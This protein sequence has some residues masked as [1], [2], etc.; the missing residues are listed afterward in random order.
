[1]IPTNDRTDTLREMSNC[2]DLTL[3]YVHA[4]YFVVN[5]KVNVDTFPFYVVGGFS[6]F[7]EIQLTKL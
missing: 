6:S 7:I 2:E 1:M 4:F 5:R 3:G